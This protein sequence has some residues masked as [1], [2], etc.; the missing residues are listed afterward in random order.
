[1]K[2]SNDRLHDH[3]VRRQIVLERFKAGEVKRLIALLDAIHEDLFTAIMKRDPSGGPIT[4]R[5]MIRLLGDVA[6]INKAAMSK[7]R[8]EL[9]QIVDELVRLE[10]DEVLAGIIQGAPIKFQ[11]NRVNL[12]TLRAAVYTRP[13]EGR[14]LKGMVAALDKN[15]KAR[16]AQHLRLGV[17]EGE[18]IGQIVRRIRGTRANGY[19]DGILNATRRGAEFLVRTSVN[20]ISTQA[21]QATFE[22]NQDIIKGVRWVAT[23]DSRTTAICAS[24]DGKVYPVDSGPRPPAHGGCRSTVTPVLKSWKELGIDLSEAPVGTRASLDGQVSATTTYG[25]WLKSQPTS[26]VEEVLGKTK[27]K[28]FL[29]GDLPIER[30]VMRNG[31]ELTLDQLKRRAPDAFERAGLSDFAA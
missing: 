17:A 12:Q 4:S 19:K 27:A 10:S 5:R 11:T 8:G 6:D 18:T 16:I 28:L 30:F 9:Y 21:R 22:G 29:K 3:T 25:T 20:H 23:L 26:V 15:T 2:S 31:H 13:L 24:R 1:M 7:F 14:F